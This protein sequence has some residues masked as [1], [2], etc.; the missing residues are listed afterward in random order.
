MRMAET[1]GSMPFNKKRMRAY[2]RNHGGL[3][4]FVNDTW[5]SRDNDDYEAWV[6]KAHDPLPI[7]EQKRIFTSAHAQRL[8]LHRLKRI[9]HFDPAAIIHLDPDDVRSWA[10]IVK[11]DTVCET[12]HGMPCLRV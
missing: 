4:E 8:C 5:M 10:D 9:V 7:E 6:S 3:N 1:K 2:A 11:S 12:K